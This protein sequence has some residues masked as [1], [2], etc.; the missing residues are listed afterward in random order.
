MYKT[1][2]KNLLPF[3][4]Y[5]VIKNIK[6]YG[7]ITPNVDNNT[8]RSFEFFRKY[9]CLFIHIPKTAGVSVYRTLFDENSHGHCYLRD[10]YNYYGSYFVDR[11]FKF[12]YVR[13]PYDRVISAYYYLREGGRGYEIDL[14][15]QKIINKSRNL[16]DFVVNF[17][18]KSE[19]QEMEH[20]RLQTS[21]IKNH[22]NIIDIDYIGKYENLNEDFKVIS[23]KLGIRYKKM[24]RI[25]TSKSNSKNYKN[26][27][28]NL[29]HIIYDI[30]KEDF[31]EF[32]Y[33]K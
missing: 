8:T 19:V 21:W 9:N 6:N 27:N 14:K 25:N 13:N 32:G 4:L 7:S 20:F 17:L 22:K 1:F 5:V 18:T 31:L 12:C 26:M 28:E 33:P 3:T 23:T 29:R 2:L 30:Y 24:K 16:E 10:Y 15:Y 11:R